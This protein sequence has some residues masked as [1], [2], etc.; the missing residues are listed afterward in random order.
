MKRILKSLAIA[1]VCTAVFAPSAQANLITNGSFETYTLPA[2]GNLGSGGLTHSGTLNSGE[3]TIITNNPAS[4]SL[5]GW[6]SLGNPGLGIELRNNVAGQASDGT[7]FVELDTTGNSLMFQNIATIFG[8]QYSL[9]FDY[10]PR[11]GVSAAS[12]PIEVLWNGVSLGS[13]TGNGIPNSS[14]HWVTYFGEVTGGN[15]SSTLTFRAV[16]ASDSL[17]GSLD[18][19]TL[20]ASSVPEP[21]SLALLG[22]GLAGLGWA[23]RRKAHA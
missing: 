14:N 13:L 6:T 7:T 8:V 5:P 20:V 11:P 12:N 18:N 4:G 21:G 9:T 17:G 10:S 15:P 22:L 2:S 19:V 3:W 23:R 16:G 1:A